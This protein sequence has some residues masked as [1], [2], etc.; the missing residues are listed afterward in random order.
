MV[1]KIKYIDQQLNFFIK[2]NYIYNKNDLLSERQ[3][4][5]EQILIRPYNLGK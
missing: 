5:K 3:V 2:K 4:K 1:G